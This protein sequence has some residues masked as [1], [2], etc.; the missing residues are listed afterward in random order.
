MR[1]PNLFATGEPLFSFEFFPPKTEKGARSLLD[2]IERLRELEPSFVSVTYGAG[3]STRDSSVDLVTR[4]KRDYG[5]EA[6]AHLTCV[7]H[8]HDEIAALLD[9]LEA[10]GI[11]NIMAL[12]GDPPQ[13][14]GSFVR[15]PNGFAYA[16][17]L[18]RFIRERGYGFALG[19]AGYPEGHVECRDLDLDLDHLR[20]KVAAGLDFVVTQLFFDNALYFRF[21]DRARRAGITV[22]IVPG[23]MPITDIGQI[24]RFTRMCGAT[25]PAALHDRLQAVGQDPQTVRS[26]GVDYATAQCRELIDHGAP[27]IHFFTLNQS[28]ATATILARIRK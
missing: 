14:Q 17:E 20:Q 19:G 28:A 12:R 18:V 10:S 16:A 1:I 7:D 24:E 8:D 26:L 25:I 15:H 4:I 2:T 5:I 23:I 11:E 3:G 6:M 13:G 22:P 27:G 9:R 21:V